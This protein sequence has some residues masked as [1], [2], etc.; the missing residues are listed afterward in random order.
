MGQGACQAIEDAYV[1]SACLDKYKLNAAFA[2]YQ[3]IRMPKARQVVKTSWAIGQIAHWKH[4]L[5]V[6]LRNLMMQ[7]VPD[8]LNRK[9]S[10]KIFQ[11]ER[12]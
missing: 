9:Q 6:R 11:L 3:K 7:W 12:V 8:S 2:A 10:E 1:L 4:P 5:A